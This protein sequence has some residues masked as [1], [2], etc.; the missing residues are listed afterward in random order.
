MSLGEFICM[1][2]FVWSDVLWAVLPQPGGPSFELPEFDDILAAVKANAPSSIGSRWGIE[3]PMKR[4]GIQE[5]TGRVRAF[6]DT[7]SRVRRVLANIPTYTIFDDHEVT[8]DWNMTRDICEGQ[9]G[10]PLGLRIVQN[11][12]VA[13]A[14]CQHWGNCPEQFADGST[15]LPGSRLLTMLNGTGASTYAN[16]GPDIQACI[17]VHDMKTLQDHAG[18]GTFG[19]YHDANALTYN[20]TIVGPAHQ[21][22]MT[23]SRSWRVFP[24]GADAAP[25]LMPP[26]QI[27]AQIVQAPDPGSRALVVVV[28]TNAPPV[29]FIRSST[30]HPRLANTVQHFPDIFESWEIA[31]VA[32]DRLYKAI[33]DKLPLVAGRR[34]GGALLLSGDVHSGFASRLLFTG[35]ARF[36]DP[37]GHGQPVSA[38][39]AQLVASALRNQNSHTIDQHG[40]GYNYAPSVMGIIVPGWVP[41][42]YAGWNRAPGS[43]EHVGTILHL[44]AGGVSGTQLKLDLPTVP[45]MQNGFKIRTLVDPDYGYR[46]DYLRANT[47]ATHQSN[48]GEVPPIP[49]GATPAQRQAAAAAFRVATGNYRE[50]NKSRDAERQVVGYNN[51]GEVTFNVTAGSRRVNHTLRWFHPAH[52]NQFEITNYSVSLDPNDQAFKYSDV[53]PTKVS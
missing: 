49:P 11:A 12:L 46:L 16:D 45:V 20:Y 48:F 40:D 13:Y 31:T 24:R 9:Y 44:A 6:A 18:S 17:G 53:A 36:E 1:Y 3:L 42:G 33:T 23:D 28:S 25:D 8:D 32:T 4:P 37:A 22:I 5:E 10:S 29:Q 50:Y 7:L 52:P 47:E 27:A 26:S 43:G 30:R 21:I 34:Q 15:T 41:E 35:T 39:F 2:L 14:V 51:I 38:V 19:V